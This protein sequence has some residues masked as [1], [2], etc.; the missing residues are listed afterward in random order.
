MPEKQ[1][2]TWATCSIGSCRRHK[3]CMYVPCRRVRDVRLCAAYYENGGC[4]PHIAC[5]CIAIAGPVPP[6][7]TDRT[8]PER[9]SLER[10]RARI[11]SN[12]VGPGKIAEIP[13]PLCQAAANEIEWLRDKVIELEQL[14]D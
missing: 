7:P 3:M 4:D 14:H 10:L 8:A 11:Q 9:V 13:D 2:A 6:S 5:D 1:I 12:Y